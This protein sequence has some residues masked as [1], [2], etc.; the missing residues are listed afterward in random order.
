MAGTGMLIK[1][2]GG[3]LRS[4]PTASHPIDCGITRD[5]T[6]I[7]YAATSAPLEAMTSLVASAS[8]M[9]A[10]R[11]KEERLADKECCAIGVSW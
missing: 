1:R 8:T 11:A 7:L 10:S 2:G 4:C 9:I 3:E 5:E 6:T